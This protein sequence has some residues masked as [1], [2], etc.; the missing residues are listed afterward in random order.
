MG[1]IMRKNF[2]LSILSLIIILSV[3]CS[4][5][6][7]GILNTEPFDK[8]TET[9]STVSIDSDNSLSEESSVS[10]TE[11]ITEESTLT[12]T[13]IE[14][15]YSDSISETQSFVETELESL[16]EIVFTLDNIPVFEGIPYVEINDNQP[17]FTESEIVIESFEYYS[18]LDELGRCGY[19]M[20]SV[21]IDLMPTENRGDISSVKPTAWHSVTYSIIEGGYLYNRCH[22]IGFQL[23]GENANNR[24]LITGTRYLNIKGMLPFENMVTEYV[25]DT[26]NHVMYRVTPIFIDDELLA[27]GILIEGLSVEDDGKDIC[28]NVYCFNVQPGI[29]IDYL[30]GNSYL[31]NTEETES[32]VLEFTYI[33]NTS[34]HKFHCP[35]CSSAKTI[36]DKN[37]EYFY[38]TRQEAI[39]LGYSPCGICKP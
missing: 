26:G 14:E 16:S 1:S 31:A 36:S 21:G 28:F 17:Y 5:C 22:L 24:N 39:D 12:E 11:S 35:D 32:D 15:I 30:N 19:A 33:F 20:S 18:P 8:T 13:I 37:K 7:C 27:R 2:K 23:T 38:G 9:H 3:I 34:S 6:S 29:N 4:F 10:A 25:K